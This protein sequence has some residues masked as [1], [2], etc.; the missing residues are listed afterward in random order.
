MFTHYIHNHHN[1]VKKMLYAIK[2]YFAGA[3]TTLEQGNVF[4]KLGASLM[5]SITFSPVAWFWVLLR[6]HIIKD[7]A[8]AQLL[9]MCLFIDLICGVWKHLKQHTFN[10]KLMFTG[11]I[12]KVGVTFLGMIVF[13]SLGA[14]QEWDKIETIRDYVVLVGKLVNL[15][16]VAGSAFNSMFVITGGKFPPVGWMARMKKF[17]EDVDIADFKEKLDQQNKS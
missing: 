11:F 4:M 16:Y 3:F 13:N 9:M 15:I 10:F 1:I 12:E 14:I 5:L 6:D 2:C 8:F 17:N 7:V